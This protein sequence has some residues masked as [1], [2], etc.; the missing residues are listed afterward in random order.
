MHLYGRYVLF[1]DYS[2]LVWFRMQ[3][4]SD[5]SV[6]TVYQTENKHCSAATF[7]LYVKCT[8]LRTKMNVLNW[9]IC[10]DKTLHPS[11]TDVDSCDKQLLWCMS[12]SIV[13]QFGHSIWLFCVVS[14]SV[15][16]FACYVT[17]K[18]HLSLCPSVTHTITWSSIYLVL[19]LLLFSSYYY[20]CC[21]RS[22][23]C[24]RVVTGLCMGGQ[25]YV[26][27]AMLI[28]TCWYTPCV[29]FKFSLDLW[30][31]LHKFNFTQ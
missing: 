20:C 13:C 26:K 22:R 30:V 1:G 19:I 4:D 14:S 12:P 16:M 29:H 28:S 8:L 17:V 3:P 2:F 9:S 10:F 27:L 18:G 6:F 24:F 15:Q 5:C 7:L 11:M 23:Y 25:G 31:F 21:Y